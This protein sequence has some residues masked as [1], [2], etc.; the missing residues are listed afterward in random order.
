M[1]I[2]QYARELDKLRTSYG[3]EAVEKAVEP[4][5]PHL[6]N[7]I[8]RNKFLI[9]FLA[10]IERKNVTIDEAITICKKLFPKLE[11]RIRQAIDTG[12]IDNIEL[13]LAMEQNNTYLGYNQSYVLEGLEKLEEGQHQFDQ[14]DMVVRGAS[15]HSLDPDTQRQYQR[16]M[17]YLV[18]SG[19]LS[20]QEAEDLTKRYFPVL[21]K[22]KSKPNERRYRVYNTTG[23]V[24][25]DFAMMG[26]DWERKF[27]ASDPNT[28]Q[29]MLE[30]EK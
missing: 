13:L 6:D 7:D 25:L 17:L 30:D 22:R 11:K 23:P 28:R 12:L 16:S 5:L 26:S 18:E 1:T 27:L 8:Y 21:A 20:A 3:P 2:E 19:Q 24:V 9:Q 14:I 10:I 15:E 4:L 29:E